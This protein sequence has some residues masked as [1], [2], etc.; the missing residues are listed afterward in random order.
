MWQDLLAATLRGGKKDFNSDP[1]GKYVIIHS[2]SKG[3]GRKKAR[4][5]RKELGPSGKTLVKN[6]DTGNNRATGGEA[7]GATWSDEVLSPC[8]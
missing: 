7:C 3:R 2:F 8:P 6:V 1:R 5:S 4:L